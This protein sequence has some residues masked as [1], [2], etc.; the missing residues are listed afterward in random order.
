MSIDLKDKQLVDSAYIFIDLL[1]EGAIKENVA[2]L[3][4]EFTEAEA[5]KL[6]VN[7]YLVLR[8]AYFNELDIYMESK[9]LDM[10]TIIDG[11]CLYPRIGTHY[12]NLSFGYGGHCLPKDMK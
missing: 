8:V 6:F 5:V 1:Q 11:V 2:T 10:K 3:F 4:M 9:G 12:N 7:T